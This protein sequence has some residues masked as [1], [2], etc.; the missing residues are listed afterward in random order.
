MTMYRV[1]VIEADGHTA[2]PPKIVECADD[3]AAIRL[4]WQYLDGKA[5]EIWREA[6]RIGRLEP[7]ILG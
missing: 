2:S 3:Q 6:N 1:Y 4:A 5:V 7:D